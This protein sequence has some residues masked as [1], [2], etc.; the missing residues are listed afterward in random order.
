MLKLRLSLFHEGTHSLT[1]V[2]AA[3]VD[4]DHHGLHFKSTFDIHFQALCHQLLAHGNGRGAVLCDSPSQ[5]QAEGHQ[6]FIRDNMVHKSHLFRSGSGDFLCGSHHLLG[7]AQADE[8][9][10]TLCSARAWNT[11]DASLR[12]SH[13]GTLCGHTDITGNNHLQSATQGIAINCRNGKGAP[14]FQ[15]AVHLFGQARIC[16]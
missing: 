4:A 6:L 8:P 10:Q 5:F 13:F 9:R 1:L 14:T 15:L 12:D 11:A 16:A 3:I 2:M 7:I